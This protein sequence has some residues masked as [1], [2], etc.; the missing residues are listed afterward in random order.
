MR[1]AVEQVEDGWD[2]L[3]GPYNVPFAW[4]D[5][6][7]ETLGDFYMGNSDPEVW[8]HAYEPEFAEADD[9]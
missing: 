3:W 7:Y 5:S 9:V 8:M 4:R 6:A 2:V 1:R